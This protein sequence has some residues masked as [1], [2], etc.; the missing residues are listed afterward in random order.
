M[1]ITETLTQARERI[2]DPSKW[3]KGA[4]ARNKH[5]AA[6]A[7]TDPEAVCWCSFGAITAVEVLS[8]ESRVFLARILPS[9]IA[10][11]NDHSSHDQILAGFD[12]AIAKAKQN[13][14]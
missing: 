7:S 5:G 8:A 12:L 9:N 11:W 14:I 4:F 2:A 13:G 6:V 10:T 1:S 3:T